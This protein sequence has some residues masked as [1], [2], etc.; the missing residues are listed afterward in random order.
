MTDTRS[1]GGQRLSPFVT[2][3]NSYVAFGGSAS[4]GV[5]LL[6][7]MSIQA[8]PTAFGLSRSN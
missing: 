1:R 5:G 2:D 6:W 7:R 4:H 8:M 3:V